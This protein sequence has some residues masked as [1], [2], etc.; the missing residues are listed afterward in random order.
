MRNVLM[1][2]GFFDQIFEKHINEDMLE[3]NYVFPTKKVLEYIDSLCSIPYEDYLNFL[4]E[5]GKFSPILAGDITQNS[6]INDCHINLCN[7]LSEAGDPGMDFNAIGRVLQNDGVD[8]APGADKKYG[9]NHVKTASQLGLAWELCGTWYLTCIGRV[10]CLLSQE[11]Q[12]AIMARCMLRSPFYA[13]ILCN[14]INTDIYLPDYMSILSVSTIKRRL[15]SVK[16]MLDIVIRAISN[17]DTIK[18]R[19]DNAIKEKYDI[20]NKNTE[21]LEPLPPMHLVADDN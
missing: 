10:F 19:L 8:R 18:A 1:I 3:L 21:T 2:N 12:S 13:R 5:K 14:A 15:P 9:E 4:I 6:N 7:A 16:K 17:S 11:T 20:K